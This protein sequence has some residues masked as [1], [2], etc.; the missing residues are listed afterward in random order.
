MKNLIKPSDFRFA[1]YGKAKFRVKYTS[2][3]TAMGWVRFTT[4]QKLIDKLKD[5]ANL[6]QD[7][8]LYLMNFC[9]KK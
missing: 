5:L 3:E 8:L 7:D 9:K 4:N 2:P 1:F 6:K